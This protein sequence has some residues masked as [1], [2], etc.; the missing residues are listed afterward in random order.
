M[1]IAI[2]S[3]PKLWEKLKKE[4][5]G[6]W[7]ARKAQLL[8]KLYKQKGGKFIGKKSKKNSLVKWTKE[9]WNYI[10]NK[11]GRYLPRK[12]RNNLSSK[13]K[14]EEN[15]RKLKNKSKNVKYSNSVYQKMKKAKIF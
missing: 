11:K 12:V 13:E 4:T 5:P 10:D 3:N 14:Y 15:K 1:T 2:K 8:V 6:K 7:S 9:D